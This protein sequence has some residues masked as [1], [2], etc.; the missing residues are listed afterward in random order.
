MSQQHAEFD[1]RV[2]RSFAA[3]HHL[4][5]YPGDCQ[6][7]HGH[8]WMVAVVLRANRLNELGFVVDFKDVKT[9][10]DLAIASL[11]HTDLNTLPE[12]QSVNPS[13]EN[14]AQVL[15]RRI[16]AK[17]N[18]EPVRLLSVQLDESPDCGII[19]REVES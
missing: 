6:R 2:Q 19:Y 12:F 13:C 14:V 4:R 18:A 5:G 10:V 11:D 1:L 9:A 3:A 17:L 15:Y 8:T 16:L 7:P